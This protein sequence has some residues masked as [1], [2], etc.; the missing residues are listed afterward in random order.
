MFQLLRD[1]FV[2]M[3]IYKATGRKYLAFE[4]DKPG[5]QPPD[6]FLPK[7][8]RVRSSASSGTL[9]ETDSDGQRGNAEAQQSGHAEKGKNAGDAEKGKQAEPKK[10]GDDDYIVEFEEVRGPRIV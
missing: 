2:G 7:D 4:E 10:D 6:R 3:C 1:S 9:V 5:Y 8:Q